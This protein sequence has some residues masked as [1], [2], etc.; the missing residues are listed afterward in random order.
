MT[1]I[2]FE[3]S[4]PISIMKND[5]IR[6]YINT[7][8]HNEHGF[9][10]DDIFTWDDTNLEYKHDY[11][12]WFFPLTVPSQMHPDSPVLDYITLDR[13]RNGAYSGELRYAQR[14]AFYRMLTF[15][16][17]KKTLFGIKSTRKGAGDR[18][19]WATPNNH[20]AL[21]ITRILTSLILFGNGR[22]AK[23]FYT[24][25]LK[26]EQE[27]LK[28]VNTHELLL[29]NVMF[30]NE[31]KAYWKNAIEKTDPKRILI[32]LEHAMQFGVKV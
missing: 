20:N 12:Q 3:L 18:P 15:Y 23:Q 30:T 8:T 24:A 22:L 32:D 5:L 13:I 2:M 1:E 21:R 16:G 7:D 17:F 9:C 31:V 10:F 25:I 4:K 6:F 26:M 29:S 28:Y 27:Y 19:S 14:K 11:I